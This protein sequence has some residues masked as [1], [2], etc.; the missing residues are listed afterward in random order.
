MFSSVVNVFC[1]VKK[2]L[3]KNGKLGRSLTLPVSESPF[4][5]MSLAAVFKVI[6]VAAVIAAPCLGG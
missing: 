5:P 2:K 1:V 4:V 3:K 6:V